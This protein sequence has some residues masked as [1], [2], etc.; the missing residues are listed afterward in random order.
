GAIAVG[1]WRWGASLRPLALLVLLVLPWLPFPVPA[2]F[3]LWGRPFSILFLGAVRSS[4][5]IGVA[6]LCPMVASLPD[7][8][9]WPAAVATRPRTTAGV[10]A[11]VLFSFSALRAAPRVFRA[12]SRR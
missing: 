12:E 8:S 1:L 10:L 2:A 5:W 6:V 9:R 7:R 3:L 11:A 4:I